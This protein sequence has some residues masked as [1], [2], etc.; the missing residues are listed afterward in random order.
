MPR[1]TKVL[2]PLIVM[3]LRLAAPRT[4]S[5]CSVCMGGGDDVATAGLNAA[6]LTLLASL[7][8]VMG[9][10]VGFIALLIRQSVKHPLTRPGAS[11]GVVQ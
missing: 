11:G 5:A 8:V 10:F 6:V 1:I 3:G 7:L 2:V 9:T 4:T